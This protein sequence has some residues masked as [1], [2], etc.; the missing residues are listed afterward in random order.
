MI[1]TESLSV[2]FGGVTAINDLSVTLDG[3]VVGLIGPNGAGKTT[4]LNVL[5]GFVP[6]TRG[7][8]LVDGVDQHALTAATRARAGLRRTFQTELVVEELTVWDNVRVSAENTHRRYSHSAIGRVLEL[9]ELQDQKYE[10]VASLDTFQRRLVEIARAAV[11]EPTHILLDE[12]GAGL[13]IDETRRLRDLIGRLRLDLG[14]QI[15]LV[16]HDVDLIRATCDTAV[17]LDFGVLIACGT[18]ADV[19]DSAEVREAYLGVAGDVRP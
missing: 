6:P 13:G 1:V 7:R 11:G 3:E 16:D 9:V 18:T 15:V 2:A 19:L 5:S 12:P 10:R 14:A 17:C 8:V 4:L